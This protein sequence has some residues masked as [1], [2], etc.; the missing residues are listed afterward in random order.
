MRRT[1]RIA[2]RLVDCL[3]PCARLSFTE[4]VDED[5]PQC[6]D[7]QP[8]PPRGQSNYLVIKRQ[9]EYDLFYLFIPNDDSIRWKSRRR[10]TANE[11]DDVCLMQRK[12]ETVRAFGLCLRVS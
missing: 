12:G 2:R 3:L 7:D 9:L 10:R 8:I 1:P 11:E 6:D 5:S 4:R